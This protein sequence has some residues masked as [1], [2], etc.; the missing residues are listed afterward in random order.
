MTTKLDHLLQIRVDAITTATANPTL[1]TEDSTFQQALA[2]ARDR[3][4]TTGKT[5]A[6]AIKAV[7]LDKGENAAAIARADAAVLTCIDEHKVLG[8]IIEFLLIPRRQKDKENLPK[9]EL[10][11]RTHFVAS[12]FGMAPSVLR[13]L[14]RGNLLLRM[15]SVFETLMASSF[16]ADKTSL[17]MFKEGID[18]LEEALTHLSNEA[19]DDVPLYAALLETREHTAQIYSAYRHVVQGFLGFSSNVY[20]VDDFV[21]HEVTKSQPQK[22]EEV[23]Q[24]LAQDPASNLTTGLNPVTLD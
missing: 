15:R 22:A 4:S 3:V 24:A 14:G 1:V 19:L 18:E 10:E 7:V 11:K 23:R 9:G 5:H 21:L 20:T 8:E 17:Q 16:I 6:Q 2:V 13:G 12:Q